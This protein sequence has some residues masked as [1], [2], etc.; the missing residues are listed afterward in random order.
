MKVDLRIKDDILDEL[1]FE[2]SIDETD[3]GVIVKNGIVTLTGHVSNYSQ[4]SA[5]ESA[6]MRVEG[7]KAV[8]EEIEVC[9]P[10]IINKTDVEVAEE[11]INALKWN[12]IV[13]SEK[14]K[15]KVENGNVFLDG[16]LDWQ[17]QKTSAKDA[18]SSLLGVKSVVNRITLASPIKASEVKSM[19]KK[20]LER[21]ARIDANNISVE[22]KDHEVILKGEVH[23]WVEKEE[24]YRAAYK[25]PGVWTVKNHIIVT[26]YI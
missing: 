10:S 12:T 19:I 16:Q 24:A 17:Y 3:I 14:V 5:A 13:P 18:I 25:V 21:A 22:A 20:A 2:P 11:A 26:P 15:V 8:V 6:A 4:K 23:S 9:F 7:V 1:D